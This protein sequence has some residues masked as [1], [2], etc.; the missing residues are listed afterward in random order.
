[1]RLLVIPGEELEEFLF[2]FPK[3]MFRLLKGEARRLRDPERWR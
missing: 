2:R 1:M 3:V